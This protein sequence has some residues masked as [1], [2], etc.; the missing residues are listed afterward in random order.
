M[1]WREGEK[2]WNEVEGKLKRAGMKWR[3]G[4]KG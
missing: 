2:G 4:E 1:K 3:E